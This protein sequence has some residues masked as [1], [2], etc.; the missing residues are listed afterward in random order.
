MFIRKKKGEYKGKTYTNYQ[1]VESVRT[2]EGPRQKVVCSL[3]NLKARSRIEWL[4]LARKV[5]SALQGQPDLIEEY[6]EEVTDIVSRVHEERKK[7]RVK[8]NERGDDCHND[9]LI[10]VRTSGVATE[11]HREAGSVHVGYQYWNKLGLEE[12]LA[13]VGL[14]KRE[15]ML[16]CLMTMNR[17]FYPC[18]EHAMPD[19]IRTSAL[20]DILGE[21]LEALSDASLYRN[22]D[23][24]HPKR[25]QIESRLADQERTLFNLDQTIFL[26]DLTSTYFEGQ[27]KKNPKAKKGYSRDKRPDCDQVVVGLVVNR[28]GFPLGH[29]VFEG[30]IRDHKTVATMLDLLDGRMGLKAG[31]TVVVDRGMSYDENISQ[32]T[33]RG[34]HYL[35]A[36]R[37]AERDRWLGE[38]EDLGGFDEIRLTS[39]ATNPYQKKAPIKVMKKTTEQEIYV[40]CMSPGRKQKDKAIR[41]KQEQ[42]LIDDLAKLEKRVREGRLVKPEKIGEAIG[43]LKERYP[44]VARYYRIEYDPLAKKFSYPLIDDKHAVATRLDG[45]YLLKSDRKD[46]SAEEIWRTYNLLT[47]AEDAFRAMK[48]PLSERPI[49]HQLERRVETHIFLCILAYHLMVAIE[50]M[51]RDKGVHL[52]FATVRDM[53]K[54]HQ[55]C[56]TVLPTRDGTVLKIR[57]D[58]TAEPQH[59]E[60]YRLLEVPKKIISPKKTWINL[61][62][63]P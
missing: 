42:R 50:K 23:V 55:V 35:V 24:L 2:P 58:S 48:S 51:L 54:T 59:R 57:K 13:E 60:L 21:D 33:A 25:A 4:N 28:D 41:E 20:P 1:L 17:L 19:W 6:D 52:S 10:T 46:L 26:Y 44:R 8:P 31:Q 34:L 63:D 12:I 14:N 61:G 11:L 30:N 40:L 32:I 16:T 53:L 38:Y 7:E 62:D 9:D 3:G 37:Q 18:S 15:R 49:F 27:T 22:L 56:T 39:S 43:R 47:K 36:S 5:E 29:E 45:S